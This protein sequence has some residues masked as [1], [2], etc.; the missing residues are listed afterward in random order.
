MLELNGENFDR[1]ILLSPNLVVVDF[2][3]TW[4]GPCKTAASTLENLEES[5]SNVDFFKVD[6]DQSQDLAQRFKVSSVPTF[7]FIRNGRAIRTQVGMLSPQDLESTIRA[8]L[9]AVGS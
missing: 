8:L 6:I 1:E 4:C 3:A 7:K 5:Y 2:Y 9:E